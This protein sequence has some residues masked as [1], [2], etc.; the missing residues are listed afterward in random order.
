VLPREAFEVPVSSIL[1]GWRR[2]GPSCIRDKGILAERACIGLEEQNTTCCPADS[3]FRCQFR[4]VQE[5]EHRR[6]V[7]GIARSSCTSSVEIPHCSGESARRVLACPW[8]CRRF[9]ER[10]STECHGMKASC[11]LLYAAS[12]SSLSFSLHQP[13]ISPLR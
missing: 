13:C 4:R 9:L 5:N 2:M 7:L 8:I 6:V 10:V 11:H 1:V 3:L 12:A